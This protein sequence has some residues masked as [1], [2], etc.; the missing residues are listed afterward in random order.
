MVCLS[1]GYGANFSH[2]LRQIATRLGTHGQRHVYMFLTVPYNSLKILQ[3][4]EHSDVNAVVCL[5]VK[6]I[7]YPVCFDPQKVILFFQIQIANFSKKHCYKE[8]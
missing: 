3:S 4:N 1:Y 5:I 7:K 6:I 2:I 8:I